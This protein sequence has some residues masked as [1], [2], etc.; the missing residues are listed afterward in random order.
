MP[1]DGHSLVLHTFLPL[2]QF[3]L[4][5]GV[6]HTVAASP[7]YHFVPAGGRIDQSKNDTTARDV[8]WAGACFEFEPR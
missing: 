3:F 5:R 7:P 1:A 4:A 8:H 2:Q 6:C